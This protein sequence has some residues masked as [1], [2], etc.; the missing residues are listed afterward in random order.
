MLSI[1]KFRLLRD[2]DGFLEIFVENCEI[3][4]DLLVN[5]THFSGRV[6]GTGDEFLL[7]LTGS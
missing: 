3:E 4:Y 5:F 2:S 1:S 6:L 7:R